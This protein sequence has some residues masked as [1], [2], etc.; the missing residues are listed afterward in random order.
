MQEWLLEHSAIINVF[1]NITMLLVWVFYLQIFFLTFMRQRRSKI[2]INRATGKD[3]L[4]HCLICNMSAEPIYVSNIIISMKNDHGEWLGSVTDIEASSM[5]DEIVATQ[6]TYQ[7]PLASGE[8][9][10]L[11]SFQKLLQNASKLNGATDEVLDKDSHLTIEIIIIGI[12][13]SE[14]RAVGAS[15][16]FEYTKDGTLIPQ[17]FDTKQ[18]RSYWTRHKLRSY[19][20]HNQVEIV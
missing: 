7:G 3:I 9:F 16:L 17:S 1:T 10:D 4:S 20:N 13:G 19:L 6:L 8:F 14:K 15:R 11:G 2:L 18:M 12:Y 5:E